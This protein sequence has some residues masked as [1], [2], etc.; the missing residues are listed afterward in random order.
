MAIPMLSNIAP[1]A[2]RFRQNV[3]LSREPFMKARIAR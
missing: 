3:W 2:L 1:T